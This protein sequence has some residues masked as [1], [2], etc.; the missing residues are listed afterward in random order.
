M[1]QPAADAGTQRLAV[2]PGTRLGPYEVIELIGAGGMGEVYRATDTRLG[3]QVAVKV[4]PAD[5][6]SDK[7]RLRRFEHE[8]RAVAALNHPHILTV[9]DVGT[10]D[11]A[12][13][14]VAELLGGET[15][16][17]VLSRRAPSLKQ[18]LA[19]A[20][21]AAQ[22]L[23]AAHRRG[24]VHRDV[25]PENLFVTSDGQVKVLDFGLAKHVPAAPEGEPRPTLSD[26][27][28]DG[29]VMGTV[30]Y[31][32]P[33]Q[34]QGRAVDVRSDVFSFG[35][36]LYEL[37]TRKHPFRRDTPAATLGAIVETEPKPAGQLA[38]G[39]P[40][41]IEK[42]VLRCLRKDPEKRFQSMADVEL[43]L[44]E[45]AAEL[46]AAGTDS[47]A[48]SPR[49]RK[50][51]WVVAAAAGLALLGVAAVLWLRSSGRALPPPRVVQLTSYPGTEI[52]PALSP[53]G[54][55]VA[56]AWR[57]EKSDNADIYVQMVGGGPPLR[58]TTDPAIDSFPAWSPDGRELAFRRTSQASTAAYVVSALGGPERKVADLGRTSSPQPGL[59][60][61]L[62]GRALV[63]VDNDA[64]EGEGI[65]LIPVGAGERRRLTPKPKLADGSPS[66]SPDGRRLAYATCPARYQC[67]LQV[68]RLD[69]G[70][71]P[72]GAPRPLGQPN[73]LVQGLTWS[74]DGR[75]LIY[76]ASPGGGNNPYLW[77]LPLTG[78]TT[79]ER[80][81][82]AGE[83]ALQPNVAGGHDL[84]VFTR[85]ESD[86][87]IWRVTDGGPPEPF[88]TSSRLEN[89]PVFSPDGKR[90]AFCS[91]RWS[92]F[93]EVFVS[94][95]D[96]SGPMQ[97][98][99]GPGREQ[100]SPSW[101]PDSRRIA[102]DSQAADGSWDVY[103]VDAA[104]GAPRLL[105][106]SSADEVV[107]TWSRDGRWIYFASNRTGR[108]EIWRAPAEG[109]DAVPVTRAGG[110]SCEESPD[111]RTLYYVKKEVSSSQPVF[112]RPVAGGDERQVLDSVSSFKSYR[113]VEDGLYYWTRRG[114]TQPGYVLRFLD[115]GTG[116]S[117]DLARIEEDLHYGLTV[118][119]DRKT[120]L[121]AFRKPSNSDLILIENFR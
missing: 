34:A 118:S 68:L 28:Q 37:L 27:T 51:A 105:T 42:V 87:D 64:R 89:Q 109:G 98:T 25:K 56:F 18:A 35:V 19:F 101:S 113:V 29:V 17:E 55:Q 45:A 120:I 67:E 46:D 9:H 93:I 90:L 33:E 79:P 107:P 97:L 100:C 85:R 15:L 32:S 14:V 40:H 114:S 12:P 23:A 36:V 3:R 112:V 115:L 70:F 1:Q 65:Y 41:D 11:G 73:T 52:R 108:H 47:Q 69:A 96:G 43:E 103:V 117:R 24:I 57:G 74:P 20:I 78:S 71:A 16:R 63:A 4:L 60:W 76:A 80:I 50:R 88:I 8:A 119:P 82:L 10:H 2:T 121:F 26:A 81:D 31:M 77:R 83:L 84:L 94:A 106:P 58:L 44:E 54:R 66:L 104:G 59:S 7:E 38:R 99:H 61:T 53:D 116:K 39:L 72:E 92:D 75:S 5:F 95:A 30:A 111:G 13:Y 62:D 102:F 48:A 49:W 6:A 91:N 21:Q 22:G 86:T 110:F